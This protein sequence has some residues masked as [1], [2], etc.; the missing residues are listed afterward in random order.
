MSSIAYHRWPKPGKWAVTPTKP[1]RHQRDL[2]LAYSPYVADV[3]RA[4]VQDPALVNQVTNKGRTVGVISNGT[5]V[6]GLG[7]I[8]PLAGKP[9]MEGKATLF[10][11]FADVD[12]ID[13]NIDERDPEKFVDIVA[14]FAENTLGGINLEDIKAPEC[15]LIE[16]ALRKRLNI[17]VFHDDQ[18]G[19]AVVVAAALINGLKLV[20]KKIEDITCV[21]VG[22]GA[23]GI[24][25]LRLLESLGLKREN[26]FLFDGRGYV[27]QDR[28]ELQDY[29]RAYA[30]GGKMY[31]L[32][33]ALKGADM[34][35]GVAAKD[36]IQPEDIIPMAPNP[37]IFALAN[38][39]PEVCVEKAKALR[40]DGIF[41]TGRSRDPNQVNNLLCFPYLFRGLLDAQV[42]TIDDSILHA[43]VQALADLA[44]QPVSSS[45]KDAYEGETFT[46]GQNYILPKPFDPR[47]IECM[48]QAVA[49]AAKKA[50]VAQGDVSSLYKYEL[51]GH[52]SPLRKAFPKVFHGLEASKDHSATQ[53]SVHTPQDPWAEQ[54]MVEIW[55]RPQG[56]V[57]VVK[58]KISPDK[59]WKKLGKIVQSL[60]VSFI[61]G[62]KNP[63]WSITAP[64]VQTWHDFTPQDENFFLQETCQNIIWCEDH[65]RSVPLYPEATWVG[66]LGLGD[67]WTWMGEKNHRGDG[68]AF[69]A[70]IMIQAQGF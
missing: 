2:A 33:E 37:L 36:V 9:V 69:L 35:L 21:T 39:D 12:A 67:S 32:P 23:A 28:D 55:H 3:C 48:P 64:W 53:G 14:S 19:T 45:V 51:Q 49:Q 58:H 68:Q 62:H 22:A 50:G 63:D 52:Y 18:H 4:L 44:R 15:F 42:T 29:K 59:A 34:F 61:W 5:A 10:K 24:A 8:G 65:Y 56:M 54:D 25:C 60:D 43:C 57:W 27:H 20:N 70:Y 7:A 16:S 41:C 6:L 1:M 26:V 38:P 47:L 11:A 30:Q 40:P 31:T 46:F 13:I 66:S 17:P